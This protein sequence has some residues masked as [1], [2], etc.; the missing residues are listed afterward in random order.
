VTRWEYN[1]PVDGAD[2]IL[3]PRVLVANERER[4]YDGH[5]VIDK[6]ELDISMKVP[7]Y[8]PAGTEVTM[9]IEQGF[10]RIIVRDTGEPQ[11]GRGSP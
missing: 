4:E 11:S 8:L 2:L 9:R 1:L 3:Y 6:L 10:L 7:L 5:R